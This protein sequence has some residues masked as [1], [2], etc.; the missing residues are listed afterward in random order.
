MSQL[1]YNL[2]NT[3]KNINFDYNDFK[4]YIIKN[5]MYYKARYNFQKIECFSYNCKRYRPSFIEEKDNII[6]IFDE[7]VDVKT[8][9]EL[10]VNGITYQII[11]KIP[12]LHA[13]L[14]QT[15]KED[16]LDLIKT[17]ESIDNVVCAEENYYRY[18]SYSPNDPYWNES[19][20]HRLINCE[21]AWDQSYNLD[22]CWLTILDTGIDADHED[23]RSANIYQWDIIENDGT[24]DDDTN[25]GHGTNVTGI[26]LARLNNNLGIS[27][28]AGDIPNIEVI[29]IFDS[30]KKTSVWLILKA[31][32]YSIS[33]NIFYDP[34]IICMCF[35]S[36]EFSII[37]KSL[38]D[39]LRFGTNQILFIAAVGNSGCSNRVDYP[40]GYKSVLSVGAINESGWLCRYPGNWGSN[41]N[42]K[43]RDVDLVAPGINIITT[44]DKDITE[45]NYGYFCGTSAATAYVLGVAALWY[46]VR[47]YIRNYKKYKNEPDRCT[48]ALIKGCKSVGDNDC[49]KYGYGLVD[50]YETMPKNRSKNKFFEDN[51]NFESPFKKIYN[52][53][54][55][56]KIYTNDFLYRLNIIK[57]HTKRK[58]NINILRRI[59]YK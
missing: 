37:E 58:I 52:Y 57:Y 45:K 7:N 24:A 22:L 26:A 47:A 16:N 43:S 14:I 33:A 49:Y 32:I 5:K 31:L 36:Q 29:K 55:I 35:G 53:I 15:F 20:G 2:D 50:A 30:S 6:I 54:L 25:T 8:I 27:G 10:Q 41:Y 1:R 17:L 12:K 51:K 11:D 23:L 34:S 19:W 3:P 46:G 44:T 39:V 40:A 28:V 4:K 18:L 13:V 38:I 21:K 56:K 42:K 48:E 59:G 9:D